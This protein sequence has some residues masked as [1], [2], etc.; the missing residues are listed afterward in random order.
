MARTLHL[1]C[2]ADGTYIPHCAAMLHSVLGQRGGLDLSVH[3]LHGPGL[4]RSLHDGLAR[5]VESGSAAIAFHEIP[6]AAVAGLPVHG[7][8]TPAMWYRVLAPELLGELD[9]VL[10]LDADTIAVDSL[11][12]LWGV[13]LQGKIVAAVTNVFEPQYATRPRQLGLPA[14]QPYFN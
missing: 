10:Y 3:F 1:A 13:A 2:A 12:P 7:Y 6:D 5:M 4:E 9:R 14:S 8:F 11:A